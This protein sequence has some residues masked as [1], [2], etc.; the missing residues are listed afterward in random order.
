MWAVDVQPFALRLLTSSY[1]HGRSFK[2]DCGRWRQVVISRFQE[3]EELAP[4][5]SDHEYFN[6]ETWLEIAAWFPALELLEYSNDLLVLQRGT[7]FLASGISTRRR[8]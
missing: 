5:S 7:S 2:L 8:H 1:R 6:T 3:K 4:V